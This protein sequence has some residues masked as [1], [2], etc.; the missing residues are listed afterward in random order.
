MNV[1]RTVMWKWQ[2]TYNYGNELHS[3]RNS[4]TDGKNQQLKES[5][6][7]LSLLYTNF[8]VTF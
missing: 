4:N 5:W 1:S 2:L 3:L 8:N 7:K 6:H